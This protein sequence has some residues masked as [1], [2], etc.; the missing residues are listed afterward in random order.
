[1]IKYKIY[2]IKT[3]LYSL[4]GHTPKFNKVGKMWSTLGHVKTHLNYF[5][6][7]PDT[8]KIVE[9]QITESFNIFSARSIHNPS[10]RAY[11]KLGPYYWPEPEGMVKGSP[12]WSAWMKSHMETGHA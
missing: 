12:E 1:M 2:D 9:V 5:K 10:K 6:A 4:G 7:I 11:A 3:G 8:W